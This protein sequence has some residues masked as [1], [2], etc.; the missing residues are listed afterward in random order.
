[1]S[2]IYELRRK[3][4]AVAWGESHNEE[5]HNLYPSRNIIRI[6]TEN[7]IGRECSTNKR[8]IHR[9]CCWNGLDGKDRGIGGRINVKT[10]LD[11]G[12]RSVWI[13]MASV[14][15]CHQTR[16]ERDNGEKSHTLPVIGPRLCSL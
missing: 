5:F 4:A 3:K 9:K 1:M 15:H 7:E 6:I 16:S 8:E 12:Y 10:G 2:R 13:H 14:T 11:R